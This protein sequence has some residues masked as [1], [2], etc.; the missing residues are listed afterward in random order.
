MGSTKKGMLSVLAAATL[1]GSSGVCAQ[2]IMQ[3]SHMSST[4]LTMIRLLFAGVILLILSFTHGDKIFAPFKNRRD[5]LSLIIFSLVGSLTVQLTFMLT[6][7]KSNAATATV[8]QFLSPTIIV[9][10]FALAGKKRP[11]PFVLT[12]ILTSLFGTFLLVTHGSPTSLSVSPAALIWGIASAFAAAFY[13]TYPSGLIARFGTLPIVGWSMTIA[14]AALV[15]FYAGH[16]PDM[17]VNS[18]L[19]LA[20]FYLVI[21]GTALTFSLYLTGAQMIGGPKASILSCA[22]PLS[23]ALLSLLLLGISFTLPDWLGTLL[24]LSSVVLISL[25]SRRRTRIPD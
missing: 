24:I 13:T 9:A 23:S 12:A 1:W 16:Q 25:D 14:G 15:P 18:S 21:V 7:E 3:Q 5:A 4:F 19:I 20:F 6:I 22:E 10:W 11:G 2:Y 17:V 8:L